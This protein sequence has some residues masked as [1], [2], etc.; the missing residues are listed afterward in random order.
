MSYIQYV[1]FDV[2]GGSRFYNF[3]VVDTAVQ[4]RGFIVKLQ[5]EVF[6]SSSLK[7]Q[8]GSRMKSGREFRSA[9]F[10][11]DHKELLMS[12]GLFE[13]LDA[14]GLQVRLEL[15]ARH[16]PQGAPIRDQSKI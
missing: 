12:G 7:F 3:D 15:L 9:R 10:V 8:E 14:E 6:R 4:A 1:G 13:R 11:A 16:L 5:S 2:G